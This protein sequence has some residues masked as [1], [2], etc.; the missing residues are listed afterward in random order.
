LLA[1]SPAY[2]LPASACSLASSGRLVGVFTESAL[3]GWEQGWIL[4]QPRI[5]CLGRTLRIGLHP[6]ESRK[7]SETVDCR[8]LSVYK[9]SSYFSPSR[10]H[11]PAWEWPF[12]CSGACTRSIRELVPEPFAGLE[13]PTSR[14]AA[15]TRSIWEWAPDRCSGGLERGE[16]DER[17]VGVGHTDQ[18]S[19]R[20]S[21]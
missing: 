15:C 18:A 5:P 6:H 3:T 7:T 17:Q 1:V 2:G 14:S 4:R 21:G 12:S 10:S 13:R 8:I 9:R 16:P 11:V 20:R 19:G